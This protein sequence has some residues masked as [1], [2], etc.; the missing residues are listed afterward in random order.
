[1]IG[2]V[3]GEGK[4]REGE[5]KRKGKGRAGDGRGRGRDGKGRGRE[6]GGEGGKGK[7]K[8]G[9]KRQ[10][11]YQLKRFSDWG[12]W[13][14]YLATVRL[15]QSSLSSRQLIVLVLGKY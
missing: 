1:M 5:G 13:R 6:R 9:L 15:P 4:G 12:L 8:G 14:R 2:V 3:G 7:G 10:N 11:T